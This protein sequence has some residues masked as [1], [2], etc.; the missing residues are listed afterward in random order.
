MNTVFKKNEMRT[1]PT[2]EEFL[3]DKKLNDIIYGFFQTHSYLTAD[4][5]RYCLK[6]EVTA[7]KILKYFEE[8]DFENDEKPMSIPKERTIRDMTKL[9]VNCGVLQ[10]KE[11]NGK[12]VYL[13]PDLKGG[14]YIFIKTETLRFLVNTATS[15]VIKIYAFLKKKQKEHIDFNFKDPYRFSKAKLLEIIGYC[16]N[17][18]HGELLA[19]IED[20]LTCLSNNGLIK[21]HQEWVETANKNVTQYYVLDEVSDDYIKTIKSKIKQDNTVVAVPVWEEQPTIRKRPVKEFRLP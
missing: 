21:I 5:V 3:E 13:L 18:N 16:G 17:G 15:N 4:K 8:L 1:F 6:Q 10:E 14:E 2:K 7:G 11:M 12:K 9:F 20:I 19:K